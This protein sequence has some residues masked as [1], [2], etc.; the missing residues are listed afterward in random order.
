M[1]LAQN[2]EKFGDMIIKCLGTRTFPGFKKNA[3]PV[4]MFKK[5]SVFD[6]KIFD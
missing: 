5:V 6:L 3:K 4:S 2:G 1:L